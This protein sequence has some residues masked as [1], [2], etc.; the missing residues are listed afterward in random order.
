M[1]TWLWRGMRC[2]RLKLLTLTGSLAIDNN[3]QTAVQ[4][5]EALRSSAI[6]SI[7]VGTTVPDSPPTSGPRICLHL[8]S[9]FRS[10]RR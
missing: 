5:G 6:R 1:E 8:R 3:Q 4:P 2:R 7:S 10:S 9:L